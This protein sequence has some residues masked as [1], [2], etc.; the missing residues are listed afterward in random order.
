MP[1][2]LQTEP[3]EGTAFIVAAVLLLALAGAGAA[4]PDSPYLAG[5]AAL[6]F[7]G[8]IC[9][10]VATRTSGIPWLAPDREAVDV[11]GVVTNV[12]EALGLLLAF[13][14]LL[15]RAGRRSRR[16]IPQEVSR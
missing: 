5:I 3:R 7:A 11:L 1:E 14:Q 4:R 6:L 10:Y 13:D 15:Q 2:H 16:H 12:V 8:L 9:A